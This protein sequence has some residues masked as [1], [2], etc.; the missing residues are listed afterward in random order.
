M[1][2]RPARAS[3]VAPPKP[4]ILEKPAPNQFE[5]PRSYSRLEVGV[6][7]RTISVEVCRDDKTAIEH[8][9]GGIRV[10]E[11][12]FRRIPVCCVNTTRP[13]R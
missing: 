6:K 12:T 9:L 4:P 2:F 5:F 3:R 11:V 10:S 1:A 13:Y 8:F 7:P